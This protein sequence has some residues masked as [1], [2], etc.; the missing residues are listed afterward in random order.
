MIGEIIGS[1]LVAAAIF[2]VCVILPFQLLGAWLNR[3]DKFVPDNRPVDFSQ[4]ED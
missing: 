4:E 1:L 2:Y 3:N